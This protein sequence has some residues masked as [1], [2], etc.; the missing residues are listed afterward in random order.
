MRL[1]EDWQV[2]GPEDRLLWLRDTVAAVQSVPGNVSNDCSSILL[3]NDVYR[4]RE[5]AIVREAPCPA[6]CYRS[7]YHLG[8]RKPL[9]KPRTVVRLVVLPGVTDLK[10][11]Y[12][13]VVEC[14]SQGLCVESVGRRMTDEILKRVRGVRYYSYSDFLV[15]EGYH[16]G[17]AGGSWRSVR[18]ARSKSLAEME[19][20]W[21][22]SAS[23]DTI[24]E[25]VALDDLWAKNRRGRD[26]VVFR[27][28][29]ED[30]TSQVRWLLSNL[31]LVHHIG[32]DVFSVVHRLGGRIVSYQLFARHT[33]DSVFCFTRRYN[34]VL[35]EAHFLYSEMDEAID[36]LGCRLNDGC[37]GA[38]T[39]NAMKIK[40]STAM[41][42]S[43]D[44]WIG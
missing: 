13:F 4:T 24:S 23:Q 42:N 9:G 15:T 32:C 22:S 41:L 12:A 37:G 16:N 18:R 35:G 40:Y 27:V 11:V 38:K 7:L 8:Y 5:V 33:L 1:L 31:D 36:R 20:F 28:H 43:C 26:G 6:F 44:L 34:Q 19:S 29:E 25:M 39:L 3:L 10:G 21:L 2:A 14:L 17:Y 30:R